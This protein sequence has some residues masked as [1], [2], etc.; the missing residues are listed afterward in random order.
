LK[1]KFITNLGFLLVL[2]VI[3]KPL[4]VFGIDRVV[5]NRVGAEVYGSYIWLFNL[6]LIFQILLDLGIENFVR[7]EISQYPQRVSTY[8]S[9]I[10]LLKA[11]LGLLYFM[12]C[13]LVAIMMGINRTAIPLL[14]II[15]VNQFMASFILYLRANLGGL[16]LFRTESIISVLDRSVMII[17]VGA[18]LLWPGEN[19]EF[20]IKW[21]VLSQSLAYII[22]LSIN[23]YL[24]YQK[25]EFFK[26]QFNLSQILPTINNLKP[27]ALLVLL[28]SIYY[29][30]DSILLV[31]LLPDGNLQAGIYAHGFRIL[32]FLS[33]YALLFPMLLLPIFS[34]TL[35]QKNKIDDLLKLST[36]LL[37]VPSFSI[38]VPSIFYRYELFGLL[39]TEH[40]TLSANAFVFLSISYFGICINYTFGAL[41]T[42]NGNL[43]QLNIMAGIAVVIGLLCNVILIPHYKVIGAAISNASAQVFTIVYL[44]FLATKVF[45][46][47]VKFKTIVKL[48]IF[49]LSMVAL[50]FYLKYFTIF[51]MVK[52]FILS[53]FGMVI[54]FITGLISIKGIIEIIRRE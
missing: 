2:N 44:L 49:V 28:M 46:L 36:L 9:N 15:L 26:P 51:W 27:Y 1:R 10:F 7:K 41:L 22:T 42:A 43:R 16:Q 19:T 8:L 45:Q 6:A 54:A 14:A 21:F 48:I 12:L 24:V 25:V 32:D 53:S 52:F 39:Y 35:H 40:I 17:C 18:L 38:I 3:V 29:R 13:F 11:F 33:N 37:I 20:K 4:Y 47:K 23:F 34:K 31:K 50:G 5:Q 30:S